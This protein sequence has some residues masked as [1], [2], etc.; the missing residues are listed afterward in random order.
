VTDIIV[1][2][3]MEHS[4]RLRLLGS[5][6]LERATQTEWL[7]LPR[8]ALALLGYLVRHAQPIERAHL[9]GLLWGETT[10]TRG[11]RNLTRELG[12]LTRRFPGCFRSNYHTV[13]WAPP[14][15]M[16]VDTAAFAALM[17]A[18]NDDAFAEDAPPAAAAPSEGGF[19]HIDSATLDPVRLSKA[20]ALYRG[21]FLA[22]LYLD[23]CPEFETWLVREREFWRRQVTESLEKLIAYYA[24]RQHNQQ[25]QSCARRWLELEPWQE[26]AHRLLM[27]LLARSGN[28]SAALAQY[29]QCRHILAA[30]LAIEPSRELAALAA[31]IRAGEIGRETGSP[32]TTTTPSSATGRIDQ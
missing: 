23:G 20:I 24:L 29:D 31:Q 30:E 1:E 27:V 19:A 16:W 14:A 18:G 4:W 3:G 10:D 26:E 6:T 2:E 32:P 17:L 12:H 15:S 5:A 25:A 21:E 7:I 8:K 22:G 9:V 13:Q 11:R 28:R